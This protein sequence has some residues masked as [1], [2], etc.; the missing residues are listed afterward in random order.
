MSTRRLSNHSLITRLLCRRD[1]KRRGK[2]WSDRS[3]R[4]VRGLK[5][6]S[7]RSC[8]G[9]RR[10]K[11]SLKSSESRGKSKRH[12]PRGNEK[13]LRKSIEPSSKGKELSWRGLRRRNRSICVKKRLSKLLSKSA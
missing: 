4:N 6:R 8:S 2:T 9:S 13:D 10:N 12:W 7:R 1:S 3:R 5:P 11:R